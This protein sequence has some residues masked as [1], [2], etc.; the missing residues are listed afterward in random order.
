MGCN[1]T[2]VVRQGAITVGEFSDTDSL[3]QK[4]TGIERKTSAKVVPLQDILDVKK[5]NKSSTMIYKNKK[6]CKTW[7]MEVDEFDQKSH[8]KK[9]STEIFTPSIM[10][11]NLHRTAL[12]SHKIDF[13]WK[14]KLRSVTSSQHHDFT[15]DIAYNCSTWNVRFCKVCIREN[16]GQLLWAN[17]IV[18]CKPKVSRKNR[19]LPSWENG[20]THHATPVIDCKKISKPSIFSSDAS[21]ARSDTW[22]LLLWVPKAALPSRIDNSWKRGGF[23]RI[24]SKGLIVWA[25]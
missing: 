2:K 8:S 11:L 17:N 15:G 1:N 3:H 21:T 4:Y 14:W 22:S 18:P 23:D 19:V 7:A 16:F 13:S 9:C 25:L 10:V 6:I 5:I 20:V 24:P 12:T